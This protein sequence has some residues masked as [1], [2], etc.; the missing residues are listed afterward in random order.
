MLLL[1][2]CWGQALSLAKHSVQVRSWHL[3][4]A[5]LAWMVC[6]LVMV[7]SAR[8]HLQVLES[9]VMWLVTARC[10]VPLAPLGSG[11]RWSGSSRQ[12]GSLC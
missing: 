12:R 6:L 8:L 4:M 10:L 11:H 7:R 5:M 2:G 9:L 1:L 3:V